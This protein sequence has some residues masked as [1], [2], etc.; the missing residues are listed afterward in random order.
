MSCCVTDY[1]WCITQYAGNSATY[2]FKESDGSVTDLTGF[3]F[4]FVVRDTGG[5]AIFT[6]E[7]GTGITV[8]LST[9]IV[10]CSLTAAQSVPASLVAGTTYYADLRVVPLT[11]QPYYPP[12]RWVLS[13]TAPNARA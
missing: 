5:T 11:G 13:V 10:T 8:N 7:I 2:T 6:L 3:A 9:G 4:K 12:I 1:D